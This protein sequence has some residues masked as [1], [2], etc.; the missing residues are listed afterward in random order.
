[1][2][3]PSHPSSSGSCLQHPGQWTTGSPTGFTAVTIIG[4]YS[5]PTEDTAANKAQRVE[6]IEQALQ[7]G[8]SDK[9]LEG[10]VA[11]AVADDVIDFNRK[12]GPHGAT[13]EVDVETRQAI[14]EVTTRR[15]GKAKQIHKLLSNP[16]MNPSGKPVILFAPNYGHTATKTITDA[17]AVV[18]RTVAELLAILSKL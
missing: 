15:M 17:G 4:P 12:V 6:R 5:R 7:S 2:A 16:E 11:R 8:D 3:W 18:V 10:K 1:M 9:V 14:I 13:G